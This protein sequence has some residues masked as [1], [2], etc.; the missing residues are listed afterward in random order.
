MYVQE[1]KDSY[2]SLYITLPQITQISGSAERIIAWLLDPANQ[3]KTPNTIE[4]FIHTSLTICSTIV[5]V[6]CRL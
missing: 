5:T 3:V 4:I 6:Q 2:L 1:R